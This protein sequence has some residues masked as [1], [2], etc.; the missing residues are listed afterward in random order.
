[1]SGWA[2]AGGTAVVAGLAAAWLL[3]SAAT[4][5]PIGEASDGVAAGSG[6]PPVQRAWDSPGIAAEAVTDGGWFLVASHSMGAASETAASRDEGFQVAQAGSPARTEGAG[7]ARDAE[8]E[9]AA[10][11]WSAP[12]LRTVV[13]REYG[14][15]TQ[16]G[17]LVLEPSLEYQHTDINRFVVGGVAILD[18]VLVG[19]LEATEADRDAATAALTARYGVTNRFEF[20]IRAPYVYR[21]DSITNTVVSTN[22]TAAQTNIDEHGLG[23]V[24]FAWRYQ[25]NTGAGGWPFMIANLRAKAPTGTGPFDVARDAAGIEQEL[26]TGSGFWAV[27]P[28]LTFIM[29]SDPVVFFANLGYQWNIESDVSESV[30]GSFIS[31]VD[32]GDAVRLS[33]G[34]GVALNE[35][36]SMSI[37]YSQ[38][39]IGETQ[40]SIN[41]ID[42]DTETLNVGSLTIGANYVISE[43]MAVDVSLNAGLTEDAPDMRLMVKLPIFFDVFR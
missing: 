15:L 13:P 42:V 33:I 30:G 8:A 18:T 5:A 38:D 17:R 27:E 24:E 16:R 37:G 39:F 23:D 40:T 14:V 41:G 43:R 31:D 35:R 20:E 10:S 21:D 34:L 22:T 36:T 32:P 28:S 4:A 7:A 2:E 11:A 25:L 19:A 1:M 29:P 3:G 6:L 12:E 9:A 26:P